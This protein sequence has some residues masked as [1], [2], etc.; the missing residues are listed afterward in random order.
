MEKGKNLE[1]LEGI[2]IG[3]NGNHIEITHLLFA[4]DI[5]IF[6]Q[7]NEQSLL[8]LRCILLCFQAVSSPKINLNKSEL[9][10]CGGSTSGQQLSQVLL[11]QVLGCKVSQF[12]I[13]YLGVP[14]GAKYKDSRSWDPII[15]LFQNR[16]SKGG[17]LTLIKSTLSNLPIYYLSGAHN[18]RKCCKKT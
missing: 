4:D 1:L 5:L 9:V 18:S 2:T 12:P 6:C 3:K 11:S 17:G 13:K 8:D 10:V 7:P 14:L 16:L 15:E